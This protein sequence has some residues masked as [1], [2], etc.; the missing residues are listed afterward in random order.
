MIEDTVVKTCARLKSTRTMGC[1]LLLACLA[2]IPTDQCVAFTYA[3]DQDLGQ[4]EASFVGESAVD[5]L[6]KSL[7][8]A[9]D[10]NDDGFADILVGATGVGADSGAAFLILGR[11]SPWVPDAPA[12]TADASFLGEAAGDYA[13]RAVSSAG[14]VNGDGIDDFVVAATGYSAGQGGG[15][16]YLVLGRPG[17]WQIDTP[18]ATVDA[19][20]FGGGDALAGPGDIDGDGF[21]D[22]LIA[23]ETAGGEF[24]SDGVVYLVRGKA[25]GWIHDQDLEVDNDTW[26]WPGSWVHAGYFL[27]AAGDVDGDGFDDFVTTGKVQDVSASCLLLGRADLW[28]HGTDYSYGET[29]LLEAIRGR[30]V[31]D[32]N[33]DGLSDIVA[34]SYTDT[35]TPDAYLFPGSSEGWGG[36]VPISDAAAAFHA[37]DVES[38]LKWLVRGH[39]DLDGDGLDDILLTDQE[40][41][42]NGPNAGQVYLVLGR[43]SWEGVDL[44]LADAD[45]SWLGEGQGDEAGWSAAIVGDVNG[46]SFDDIVIGSDCYGEDPVCAGKVY[47]VFG[48]SSETCAEDADRD[49]YGDP[50][51]PDCPDGAETD[52]DDSDPTVHPGALEDC[53]DD[54][55]NDCDGDIDAADADCPEAADDDSADDDATGDDDTD[56]DTTTP[57]DDDCQCRNHPGTIASPLA[58]LALTTSLLCWRRFR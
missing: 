36:D 7:S 29:Y 48:E 20:F 47:L 56:A 58:I 26:L 51:S 37:E 21:D 52:C 9:G 45:A 40:N 34:F 46:D 17:D 19:S 55:D 39:G 27:A 50:G 2:T 35:S 49:G 22:L 38:A 6:G 30:G 53:E 54:I 5:L 4:A 16:T 14:D 33:G 11:V 3:L 12:S 25:G 41:D 44:S 1:Y 15:K 28:E 24:T 32:V 57:D 43:T 10:V 42:E 23:S 18:L 31:G 13:G 8:P